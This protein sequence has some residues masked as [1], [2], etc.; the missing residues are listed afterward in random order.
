M[1]CGL[2]QATGESAM[3]YLLLALVKLS[4]NVTYPIGQMGFKW[5]ACGHSDKDWLRC[6][7]FW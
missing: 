7:E 5:T 4:A 1:L 2:G 6:F 3:W